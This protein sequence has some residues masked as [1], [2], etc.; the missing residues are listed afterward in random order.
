MSCCDNGWSRLVLYGSIVEGVF[1]VADSRVFALPVPMFS[2]MM[3][4]V[5]GRTQ[6]VQPSPT[7]GWCQLIREDGFPGSGAAVNAYLQRFA[8]FV[9]FNNLFD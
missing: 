3:E 2:R 7:K 8:L 1:V 9:A 4:A 5:H 6:Y